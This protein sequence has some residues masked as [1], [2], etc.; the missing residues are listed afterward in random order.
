MLLPTLLGVNDEA[1]LSVAKD[2]AHRERWNEGNIGH[3]GWG[4]LTFSDGS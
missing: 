1:G 3:L 2:Q 4:L